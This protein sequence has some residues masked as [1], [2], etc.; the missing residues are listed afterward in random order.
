VSASIQGG[1]KGKRG[2]KWLGSGF[3][4]GDTG[5]KGG[6]KKGKKRGAVRKARRA[7]IAIFPLRAADDRKGA[8]KGKEEKKTQLVLQFQLV[9]PPFRS[10]AARRKRGKKKKKKV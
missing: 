5:L 1:K 3:R 8:E 10:S 4:L 9:L 2:S 7:A 6:G